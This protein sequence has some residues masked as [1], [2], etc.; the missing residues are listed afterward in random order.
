MFLRMRRVGR[1]CDADV[2]AGGQCQRLRVDIFPDTGQLAVANRDGE[3]PVVDE[4]LVRGFDFPSGYADDQHS[5]PLGDEL[6][7]FG[8]R[9]Q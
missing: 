5:V 6:L 3:D 8:R 7:R 1:L 9:L 4:R 2:G